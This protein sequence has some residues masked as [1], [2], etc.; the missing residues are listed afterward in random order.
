VDNI[1]CLEC[2]AGVYQPVSSGRRRKY[3]EACRPRKLG[4]QP[5]P[6]GERTCSCG[7]KFVATSKRIYCSARCRDKAKDARSSKVPCDLCGAL[8]WVGGRAAATHRCRSCRAPKHGEVAMYDKR[9][10]RCVE[11]KKVKRDSMRGYA[12]RRAAEGRPLPRGGSW[13]GR[14]ERVAIY[15]RDRLTCQL[16]DIEVRFDVMHM[17]P[18]APTLD[19]ILP[20]ALGG[21]DDPSNL[22]LACRQCN[23]SR[24]A[25]MDWS[26]NGN[27]A[28]NI[29]LAV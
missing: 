13:I 12:R 7:V 21:S 5:V 23:S 14:K 19:H 17:H 2:G 16:C 25:N 10:C 29:A 27:T 1:T 26:P 20:R 15:I 22:R 18:L 24:G 9:K 11:C 3:C 8:V 6:Q 28:Q 4:Y